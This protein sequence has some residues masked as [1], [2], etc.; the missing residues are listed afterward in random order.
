MNCKRR[1]LGSLHDYALSIGSQTIKTF[2]AWDSWV[3]GF[4]A[5]LRAIQD[6]QKPCASFLIPHND[7]GPDLVFALRKKTGN[8]DELVL[9]SIQVSETWRCCSISKVKVFS[10]GSLHQF[11]LTF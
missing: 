2:D 11:L 6:R 5:W 7:F 10:L 8:G 1:E 3:S 9:C 4:S